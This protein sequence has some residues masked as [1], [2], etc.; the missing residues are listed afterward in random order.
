M[1]HLWESQQSIRNNSALLKEASPAIER[2]D[3]SAVQHCKGYAFASL[4]DL[5][6]IIILPVCFMLVGMLYSSAGHLHGVVMR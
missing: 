6:C 1:C 3:H 2:T 4:F 5:L